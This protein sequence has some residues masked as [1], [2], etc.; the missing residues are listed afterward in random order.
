MKKIIAVTVGVLDIALLV[1]II[2][3]VAT[4]WR[5]NSLPAKETNIQSSNVVTD[6]TYI[7][8]IYSNEN[9]SREVESEMPVEIISDIQS[10][11]EAEITDTLLQSDNDYSQ[12]SNGA[13]ISVPDGS[14]F[15]TNKNASVDDDGGFSWRNGFMDMSPDA[16][17][18]NDFSAITGGWKAHFITDPENRSDSYYEDYLNISISGIEQSVNVAFAWY[19]RY[20]PS[21]DDYIDVSDNVTTFFGSFSDGSI[22]ASDTGMGKVEFTDFWFDN[23]KEYA[24]GIYTW[25]D[26][27]VGYIGL[28]R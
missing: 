4:G 21:I 24:T 1:V 5:F 23:G 6:N 15:S 28:S 22:T 27:V 2:V 20:L 18:I 13:G 26:G 11:N 12:G 19:T 14:Y 25:P 8:N 9:T 16:V 3:S 10:Q 7:N 17:R